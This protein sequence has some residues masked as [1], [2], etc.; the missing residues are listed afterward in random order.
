MSCCFIV[1]VGLK[2][3]KIHC[4]YYTS[5]ILFMKKNYVYTTQ[6]WILNQYYYKMG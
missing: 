4:V 6:E 3:M 2:G 1:L 5:M